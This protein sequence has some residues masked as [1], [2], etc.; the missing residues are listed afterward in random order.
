MDQ[1]VEAP[2]A[3]VPVQPRAVDHPGLNLTP[4]QYVLMPPGHY[5]N[6]LDNM[7]AAATRLAALSIQDE[8]PTAMEIRRAGELLQTAVAQQAAYSYSREWI[9]ST[10]R[11]SRSYSRHIDSPALSSSE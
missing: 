1:A 10:P 6:P 2:T 11:P 7:I 3:G 5:S 9:H 8:S 4:P